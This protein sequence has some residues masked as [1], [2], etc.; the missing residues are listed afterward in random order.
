MPQDCRLGELVAFFAIGNES[1]EEEEGKQKKKDGPPNQGSDFEKEADDGGSNGEDERNKKSN[2]DTHKHEGAFAGLEVFVWD[3]ALLRFC[4]GLLGLL[5][6]CAG[7]IDRFFQSRGSGLR[8]VRVRRGNKSGQLAR[9]NPVRVTRSPNQGVAE[10]D[11]F[12]GK[13]FEFLHRERSLFLAFEVHV[14][15]TFLF[16][17]S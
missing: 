6:Y 11:F 7:R 17:F 2:D 5:A 15:P 16:L 10:N 1:G 4:N 3:G 13:G 12:I 8:S 9:G 14:E